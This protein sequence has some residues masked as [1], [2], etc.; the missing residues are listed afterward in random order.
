LK[1][2]YAAHQVN[3]VIGEVAEIRAPRII[4]KK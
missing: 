2:I 1:R 4:M 3:G